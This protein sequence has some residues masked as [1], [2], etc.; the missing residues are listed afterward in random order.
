MAAEDTVV[1]G[2][3]SQQASH[4]A[5]VD[6]VRELHPY[7]LQSAFAAATCGKAGR[8]LPRYRVQGSAPGLVDYTP[9]PLDLE[10]FVGSCFH[11]TTGDTARFGMVVV[12][13]V[14]GHLSGYRWTARPDG[15]TQPAAVFQ[16]QHSPGESESRCLRHQQ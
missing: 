1:A 2:G 8:E 5:I 3:T 15:D 12:V 6:F 10:N 13:V 9:A 4:S 11:N 7:C 14:V 16:C